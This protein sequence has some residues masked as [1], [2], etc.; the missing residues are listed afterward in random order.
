VLIKKQF[1]EEEL[2]LLVAEWLTECVLGFNIGKTMNAQQIKNTAEF[3][4]EDYYYLK[5]EEIKFCFG[6]AQRGVYGKIY[7]RIDT[8]IIFEW[9][10]KY[11]DERIGAVENNRTKKTN[12]FKTQQFK[13]NSGNV[14][15][16][17]LK[18]H[19]ELIEKKEKVQQIERKEQQI[20]RVG[21]PNEELFNKIYQEFEK[22]EP[23][24]N[25]N[26]PIGYVLYNQKN[27]TLDE[28]LQVR[29]KEVLND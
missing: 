28:Y 9:F 18:G 6:Q 5:P 4:T 24:L 26:A 2:I 11:M 23:M 16:P 10:E 17:I 8:S 13:I 1:G 12:E 19:K 27:L 29:F 3:I 22:K 25:N 20:K 14:I 21:L 7:D 15:L